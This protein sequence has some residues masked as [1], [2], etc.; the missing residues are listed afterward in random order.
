MR[1]VIH[2]FLFIFP[3]Q[4]PIAYVSAKYVSGKWGNIVMWLSLILGQPVAILAYFH[5]YV[6][7]NSL[8]FANE[9]V[10]YNNS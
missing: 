5:D 2:R 7:V 8:P 10:P 3:L 6:I 9:T 4:V 1:R